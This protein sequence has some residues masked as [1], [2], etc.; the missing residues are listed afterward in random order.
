MRLWCLAITM[1]I[2]VVYDQDLVA[3]QRVVE[4]DHVYIVVPAEALS[5]HIQAL[6]AAGFVVSRDTSRHEGQGTASVSVLFENAY[7]ELLWVDRNVSV[8]AAQQEEFAFFERATDWLSNGTSPFGI[9]LRRTG[10][11]GTELGVPVRHYSTTWMRPGT[12]IELLRGAEEHTA[13]DLFVVPF[14]MA[15]SSWAPQLVQRH[16]EWFAHPS[17][18][19]R[20]TRVIVHGSADQQPKS[21]RTL[22]PEGVEFV[23]GETPLLKIEFDGG[24]RGY[25]VDLRPRLPLMLLQ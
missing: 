2:L 18:A 24:V 23:A 3:Q 1:A 6:C 22:E 15:A 5:S 19:R 25:T 17:G 14:Y 7:L 20:I 4:F 21:L 9:G 8:E 16:P 12:S 10:E 11:A 13:S